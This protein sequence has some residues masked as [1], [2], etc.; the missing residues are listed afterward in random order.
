MGSPCSLEQRPWGA[1]DQNFEDGTSQLWLPRMSLRGHNEVNS[2]IAKR[3]WKGEQLL[4][5]KQYWQEWEQST[6]VL[7]CWSSFPL[8]Q[9]F[10]AKVILLSKEHWQCLETFWFSQRGWKM[11][12]ASDG[13]GQGSCLASYHCTR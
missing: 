13:R 12:L 10:S 8:A 1:D 2:G 3:C 5:L 6:E 9:C 4:P 7:L 11:L